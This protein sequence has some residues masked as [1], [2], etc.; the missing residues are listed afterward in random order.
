MKPSTAVAIGVGAL[1]LTAGLAV[2]GYQLHWWLRDQSVNRTA[3]I[4]QDSYGRQNALVEQILDDVKEAQDPA[5]PAAQR[6]AIV[7]QICNSATKLT[8]VIALPQ[9]A[10]TL[11]AQECN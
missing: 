7:D 8:G 10:L 2:G 4:N 9:N 1:T 3:E 5:I 11:I 6:I